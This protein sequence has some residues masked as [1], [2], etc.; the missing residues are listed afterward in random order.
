MRVDANVSVRPLGSDE[1]RT[2][3][4]IKNLNSLRSLHRAISYEAERHIGLYEA[5]EVPQLETRHWSEEG[6]THTLRSKEEATIT[7]ISPSLIWC[8]S[9]PTRTGF[10]KSR[11]ECLNFL[12]SNERDLWIVPG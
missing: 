11:P 1:L 3:C 6:R 4:E 9:T 5:G 8:F 2:R 12:L 7:D 10:N